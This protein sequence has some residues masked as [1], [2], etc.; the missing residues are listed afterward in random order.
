MQGGLGRVRFLEE[1]VDDLDL[2]MVE[3]RS[4]VGFV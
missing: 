4:L 1:V 3:V 2:V